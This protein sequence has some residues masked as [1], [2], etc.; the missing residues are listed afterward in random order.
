MKEVKIRNKILSSPILQGGMG[1]GVSMGRLA[2]AV[3]ACGGLGCISTA[4]A[5]YL[6][7][8][9]R[10]NPFA[11]NL[12]AIASEIK[13]A[14]KIKGNMGMVA[15]NA[16]VATRQYADAVKTA[17]KAGV[18]AIISGA[19]LPLK[20]PEYVGDADVAICPIVSS[21]RAAKI[22]L[23]YWKKHYNR[24]AD[25][26]VIEGHRA[27]GHLGFNEEDI[28]EN[29]CESLE[30]ILPQVLE[31]TAKYEEEF[32]QEI[33]VFVG[34]GVFTNEDINHFIDLGASGVQ[35]ATRFI[36]T[37]ECDA[38]DEYKNVYVNAK[39]EDVRIIHSPVGMPGRAL[40]TPFI[41]RLEREGSIPID[42]CAACI[43]SCKM[44]DSIYCITD[45]LINAV[46][47]NYEEGLFFCGDNAWRLDKIVP[48]SELMDELMGR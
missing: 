24:S 9:F 32:G 48:V 2:G 33:P 14:K 37:D 5:G 46:K 19:G 8:D 16:M 40:N 20:L 10:K 6:E 44:K 23:D 21:K 15:V 47:G 38:S 11:A 28:L 30:E 27:G 17:V 31:V 12:R 3:A 39:E 29:K 18:D 45:A 34:G 4:D 42:R 22:I 26:V 41:E 25:F 1:V 13:K 43:N 35:I 36:A 7:E